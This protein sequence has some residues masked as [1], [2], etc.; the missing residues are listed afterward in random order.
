MAHDVLQRELGDSERCRFNLARWAT[1][2]VRFL[3]A[4]VRHIVNDI[5]PDSDVRAIL[6]PFG[7][8]FDRGQQPECLKGDRLSVSNQAVDLGEDIAEGDREALGRPPVLCFAQ[9]VP[10]EGDD[11]GMELGGEP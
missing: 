10:D 7:Q 1:V 2:S 4:S 3:V 11:V 6:R 8:P 5:D 9:G